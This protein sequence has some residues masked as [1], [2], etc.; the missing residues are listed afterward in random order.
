MKLKYPLIFG[1]LALIVG[2]A[3]YLQQTSTI[4]AAEA[5][6][7]HP[8]KTDFRH[9]EGTYHGFSP[10]DESAVAMGEME[11]TLKDGKAF[12][13]FA[14]GH[15]IHEENFSLDGYVSISKA[16]FDA[17]S[18]TGSADS[19]G[20]LYG[21]KRPVGNSPVFIFASNEKGGECN[22]LLLMLG[23][24]HDLLGPTILFSPEAIAH[25]DYDEEIR[26]VEQM[27]W[28]GVVPSLKNGGKAAPR[29]K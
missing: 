21:F 3:I 4:T 5:R 9:Y 16:E 17:M 2:A 22:Q 23:D 25:G 20:F 12:I 10:T 27:Y 6:R 24:L 14:T 19:E 1:S 15:E 26:K 13:R 7:L 11:M 29:P 18:E 8:S 28:P